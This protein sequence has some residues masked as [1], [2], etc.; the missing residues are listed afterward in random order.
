MPWT[1]NSVDLLN[2]KIVLLVLRMAMS[3]FSLIEQQY[4]HNVRHLTAHKFNTV[5]L[6]IINDCPIAVGVENPHTFCRCR[7][8]RNVKQT[9]RRISTTAC[10]ATYRRY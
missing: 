1:Y 6:I 3:H 2:L 5:L 7:Q 9:G 4:A 10:M 8:L